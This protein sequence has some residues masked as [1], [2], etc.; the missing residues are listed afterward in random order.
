MVQFLRGT[1]C[2]RPGSR[3]ASFR[4]AGWAPR[5]ASRWSAPTMW[6]WRAAP[7]RGLPAARQRRLPDTAVLPVDE[8]AGRAELLLLAVPDAELASLVSGLAAT[9]A[10]RPGTIVAHTSG[11]N[12]VSCWPRCPTAAVYRW[13]STP[14]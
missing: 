13:R 3:S 6:W 11:A 4:L 14:R 7:S 8:V 10:V 2:V 9:G 5:S 1:D 12:G